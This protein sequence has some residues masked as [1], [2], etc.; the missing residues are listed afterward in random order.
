MAV[1]VGLVTAEA[2][3][4]VGQVA[5]VMVIQDPVAQVRQ[6]RG[7][8]VERVLTTA[9]VAAGA[10]VELVLMQF[11]QMVVMVVLDYQIL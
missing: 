1:V 6:G 2:L 8:L 10:L 3:R 4:P 9:Q 11:H 7:M 5:V